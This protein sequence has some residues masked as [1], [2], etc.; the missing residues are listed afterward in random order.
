MG[1]GGSVGMGVD[2]NRCVSM[3]CV[4][5]RYYVNYGL[6]LYMQSRGGGKLQNLHIT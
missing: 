5:G 4:G 2:G 3:C 1:V 6:C